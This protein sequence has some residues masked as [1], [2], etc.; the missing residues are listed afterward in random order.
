MILGIHAGSCALTTHGSRSHTL[1]RR[2][3]PSMERVHSELQEVFRRVFDDDDLVI[4]DETTAA[5]V[6]GW[7]SLAHINLIIAIEKHFGVRFAARDL[8]AM[9]GT[10]QNVSN[11]VGL[12]VA[13]I[14][15]KGGAA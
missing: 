15:R 1:S 3:F 5:D 10:G 2:R 13:K 11:L 14:D 8:A 9:Q 7:D 6:G 12:L 4:T